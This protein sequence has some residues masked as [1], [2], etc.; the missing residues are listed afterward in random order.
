MTFLLNPMDDTPYS[1]TDPQGDA[2]FIMSL[3][4]YNF[5]IH[6]ANRLPFG[7]HIRGAWLLSDQTRIATL[8]SFFAW[9]KDYTQNSVYFI[10]PGKLV[11][12]VQNPVPLSQM[13][14][15]SELQ[16]AWAFNSSSVKSESCNGLDDNLSELPSSYH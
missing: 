15:W 10:T 14:S 2:N 16:C 5:K 13:S 11:K 7:V 9:A 8:N 12:W 6:W 3:L 4:Q 1:S